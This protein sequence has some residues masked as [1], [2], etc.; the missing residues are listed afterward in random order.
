MKKHY[1]IIGIVLISVLFFIPAVIKKYNSS[2]GGSDLENDPSTLNA[3]IEKIGE[4]TWDQV[5]YDALIGEINGLASDQ[6]ISVSE[7]D[8]YRSTLNINM[9]KALAIS[10]KKSLTENCY[11]SNMTLLKNASDTIS[12]PIAELSHQ[13]S[14]YSKYKRALSFKTTLHVFLSNKYSDEGAT[15]LKNSFQNAHIGQAFQNCSNIQSLKIEIDQKLTDFKKFV[16]DYNF[17][18]KS[19]DPDF[20]YY[21]DDPVLLSELKSHSFYYK[22]FLS[23]Q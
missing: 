14:L 10:Y 1:I 17:K 21:N 16:A 8:S 11:A 4:N 3:R 22:E 20:D 7:R 15:R 12:N 23:L 5:A 2:K 19:G 6:Q 9:Q 18:I 13:K